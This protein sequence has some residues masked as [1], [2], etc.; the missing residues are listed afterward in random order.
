[1]PP[2]QEKREPD[3]ASN[4][5]AASPAPTVWSLKKKQKAGAE[6][7]AEERAVIRAYEA[8]HRPKQVTIYFPEESLAEFREASKGQPFSPWIVNQVH[9]SRQDKSPKEA[10]LEAKILKVTAERDLLQQQ[11]GDLATKN[12]EA[13]RRERNHADSLRRITER[14]AAYVQA[15]DAEEATS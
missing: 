8:P 12:A 7:T 6:L 2:D 10:D 3:D 15:K 14:V 5:A 13:T 4:A 11:V 1:M 9:L